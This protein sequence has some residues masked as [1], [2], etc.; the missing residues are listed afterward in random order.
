MNAGAVSVRVQLYDVHGPRHSK[1]ISTTMERYR[2][3][4]PDTHKWRR[5][6]CFMV[7]MA[8][9][10]PSALMCR[11]ASHRA[12]ETWGKGDLPRC[13]AIPSVALNMLSIHI[14]DPQLAAVV[15]HS[16]RRPVAAGASPVETDR[17]ARP[18][19]TGARARKTPGQTLRA[20]EAL[21]RKCMKH[22]RALL[23]RCVCDPILNIFVLVSRSNVSRMNWQLL[24][25][26]VSV[27][28]T[29]AKKHA[30]WI[31]LAQGQA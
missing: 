11:T 20:V 6:H 29:S 21:A 27:C 22:L 28:R 19:S 12:P 13:G 26:I 31:L 16:A 10:R 8:L 24:S 2:E 5:V 30:F 18:A 3:H 14:A 23:D 1:E 17:A 25:G 9:G 4:G 7:C 15:S